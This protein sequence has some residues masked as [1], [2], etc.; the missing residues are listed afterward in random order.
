MSYKTDLT[1]IDTSKYYFDKKAADFAVRFIESKI[2]HVKGEWAG[3][4]MKLEKWQKEEIIYP[5]FGW[6]EV[7]TGYRKYKSAYIEIAKK[8]GKTAIAGAMGCVFMYVDSEPGES[9]MY[10]IAGNREQAGLSFRD[11]KSYIEASPYL[12]SKADVNKYS[13]VVKTKRGTRY[14]QPRSKESKTAEGINPQFAIADELHVHPDESQLENMEKSMASR[15]QPFLLMI[16]TAGDNM[17]GVGY[18]RRDYAIKVSQGIIEDESHYTLIYCAEPDDD[19]G[20]PETWKKANPN[21]GIS[22]KP[23]FLQ[24]EWLKAKHSKSSYNNFLRYHLNIW[25][26]NTTSFITD[27]DWMASCGDY[28][29]EQLKGKECYVGLDLSSRTDITALCLLFKPGDFYVTLNYFWLPEEKSLQSAD[30]KNIKYPDWVSDGYITETEGNVVD[31]DFIISKLAELAKT[32]RIK[33]IAY[34]DWN[35]HHIAPKLVEMGFELREFRQGY[36]SMNLPTK[37]LEKLILEK[38][39]FHLGNPVLRWMNANVLIKSD[40]ADNIKII[41]DKNRPNQKVD[42]MIANV[43]ALGLHLDEQL[44]KGTYMTKTK[45]IWFA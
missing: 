23:D 21:Y 9:P 7:D 32:Y 24:R 15:R 41:K 45:K 6:K 13:V 1:K 30:H 42:G 33:E 37:E 19:P 40:E 12:S 31:Y 20:D 22:V 4:P 25:T 2:K 14:F 39:Y 17:N 3:K 35:A 36:K 18:N 11:I 16:T 8:N 43:M 10:S 28:D 29:I 26:S 27:T 38:K 5:I 44:S 34:D